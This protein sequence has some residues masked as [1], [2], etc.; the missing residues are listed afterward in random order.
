MIQTQGLINYLVSRPHEVVDVEGAPK[1]VICL[2]VLSEPRPNRIPQKHHLP[3]LP[4]AM[5]PFRRLWHKG[6]PLLSG[7]C[8]QSTLTPLEGWDSD[9]SGAT[10][11]GAH[12]SLNAPIR[13]SLGPCWQTYKYKPEQRRPKR[14]SKIGEGFVAVGE[15]GLTG[16]RA[17]VW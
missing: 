14:V 13:A 12:G 16:R 2:W 5:K 8:T 4:V 15:T 11:L 6:K 1:W 17:S 7:T 9:D 3:P 10:L